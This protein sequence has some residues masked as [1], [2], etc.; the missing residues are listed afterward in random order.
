MSQRLA[1]I[2][3]DL[4]CSE[5]TVRR[6]ASEGLLRPRVVANGRLELPASEQRY[7]RDHWALLS[8]LKHV[9]RTERN[10]RLAVLFGSMARGEGRSDSDVDLLI[11]GHSSSPRLRAGLSLRLAKALDRDVHVVDLEDVEASA[12]LLADVLREGRPVLDRDGLWDA[13]RSRQDETFRR[14]DR[15]ERTLEAEAREAVLAARARAA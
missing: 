2:A 8:V 11:H 5:R 3:R 14:A 15:E 7:A 4:G 10:V 12:T 9:L 6:Y 13:L 1:G